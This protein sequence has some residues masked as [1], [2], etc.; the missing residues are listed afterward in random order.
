NIKKNL[1]LTKGLN[2]AE[3]IMIAMTKKGMGRQ[4]AHELLRKLAVETY[5]SDREYSEVLKEN[6]EIKKYMNEEEIDEAL[7]PENYI[8]TAVEQVRKVL[9]VSKHE[10]A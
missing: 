8:G 10:R 1:K 2:M 5:N 6:S 4:E 7:K 3:A 9:D